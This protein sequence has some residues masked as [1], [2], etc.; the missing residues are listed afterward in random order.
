MKS[1]LTKIDFIE[2]IMK[3]EEETNVQLGPQ[4]N[5]HIISLAISNIRFVQFLLYYNNLL[6][7]GELD[8]CFLLVSFYYY[9]QA[10]IHQIHLKLVR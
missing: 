2:E 7:E 1:K 5:Q 3:K 6:K 8:G 10:D 4:F 9:H